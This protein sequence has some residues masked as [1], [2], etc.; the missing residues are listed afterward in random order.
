MAQFA[1]EVFLGSQS[2]NLSTGF[3]IV[4]RTLSSTLFEHYMKRSTHTVVTKIR[5]KIVFQ[6]F[7]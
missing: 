6:L 5:Q 7:E 4:I 3:V 2:D 1:N